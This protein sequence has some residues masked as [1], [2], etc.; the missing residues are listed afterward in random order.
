MT[1]AELVEG[2]RRCHGEDVA[3]R[4]ADDLR[5]RIEANQPDQHA[6]I[7][8]QLLSRMSNVGAF[9]QSVKRKDGPRKMK[10]GDW[11]DLRSM[12]DLREGS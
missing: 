8:K 1:D 2:I 3:V 11:G 5:Y 9:V 12:R 4:V 6:R 7:R 10:G